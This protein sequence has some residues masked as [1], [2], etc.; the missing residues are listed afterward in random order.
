VLLRPRAVVASREDVARVFRTLDE[1]GSGS[2]EYK[3]LAKMLARR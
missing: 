2:I 3:E 1:D